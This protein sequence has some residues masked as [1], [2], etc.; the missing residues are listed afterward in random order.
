LLVMCHRSCLLWPAC[1]FTVLWGI[2]PPHLFSAQ[3]ALPSLLCVFFVVIAYYS[4]FVPFFPGWGLFCP[5]GY[6]DLAR[7]VCGSTM[8]HLAHLVFRTFPSCLST[9]VWQQRGTPPGFS[10]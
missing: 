10:V 6:A 2:A 5:G 4:V 1:L 8:Y 9:G 7:V 3:G